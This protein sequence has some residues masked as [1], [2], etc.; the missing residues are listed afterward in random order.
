MC[1]RLWRRPSACF[2]LRPSRHH[3][4]KDEAFKA[5]WVHAFKS[6]EVLAGFRISP[7]GLRGFACSYADCCRLTFVQR[8][9]HGQLK[10][11]GIRVRR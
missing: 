3:V 1:R 5:A 9:A 7:F 8:G 11:A 2:G 4:T 10:V 6:D